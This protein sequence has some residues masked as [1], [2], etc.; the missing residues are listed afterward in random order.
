MVSTKHKY[1]VHATHV[2]DIKYNNGDKPLR[3]IEEQEMRERWAIMK[4]LE[5]DIQKQIWE[6]NNIKRWEDVV[7]L[8]EKIEKM[9]QE[10][11]TKVKL[12]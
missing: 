11:V 1:D 8:Q 9:S 6:R 12:K 2:S 4:K 5:K 10:I 3:D 7:S